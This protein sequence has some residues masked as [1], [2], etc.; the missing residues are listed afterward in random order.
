MGGWGGGVFHPLP[1]SRGFSPESHSV[2]LTYRLKNLKSAT[3]KAIRVYWWIYC[4]INHQ[5]RLYIIK[6]LIYLQ[7]KHHHV[8]YVLPC[9]YLLQ[10]RFNIIS[11]FRKT[12]SHILS[13]KGLL[14]L[15]NNGVT[16]NYNTVTDNML[17]KPW[18]L[19]QNR[20]A[21]FWSD[22]TKLRMFIV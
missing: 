4:G 16:W 20:G 21:T 22:W 12:M 11:P 5:F 18:P 14:K 15:A 10:Y 3:V 17:Y 13:Y 6:N 19:M 7:I 8:G 2:K 9:W 1:E